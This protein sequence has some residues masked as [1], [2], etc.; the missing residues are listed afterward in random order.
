MPASTTQN[1]G[2]PSIMTP[3]QMGKTKLSPF[4]LLIIG[5]LLVSDFKNNEYAVLRLDLIIMYKNKTK[6]NMLKNLKGYVISA[7]VCPD[8]DRR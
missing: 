1:I 6:H 4:I 5:N 7:K 3:S 2:C 8:C